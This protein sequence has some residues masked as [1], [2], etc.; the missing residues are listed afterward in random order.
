[1]IV[2]PAALPPRREAAG[3]GASDDYRLVRSLTDGADS[4]GDLPRR[5]RIVVLRDN[6]VLLGMQ[7]RNKGRVAVARRGSWQSLAFSKKCGICM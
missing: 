2:S 6:Q 3:I 5:P 1:V 7:P 4:T